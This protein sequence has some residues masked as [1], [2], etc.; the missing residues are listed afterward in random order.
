M[1]AHKSTDCAMSNVS[2]TVVRTSQ[3][4]SGTSLPATF[5]D[6]QH[7]LD[8]YHSMLIIGIAEATV[9]RSQAQ[10]DDLALRLRLTLNEVA[11][12][13]MLAQGWIDRAQ[14]VMSST[15]ENDHRWISL[16][17]VGEA[18]GVLPLVSGA[19]LYQGHLTEL[20]RA[21]YERD[22]GRAS[23]AG[24]AEQMRYMEKQAQRDGRGN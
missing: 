8:R 16:R 10:D 11:G 14:V 22:L 3:V 6:F 7:E 23:Q 18:L 5:F 21:M 12:G 17:K 15:T 1:L 20:W 4:S 9:L 19:M 24:S 2:S 13:I